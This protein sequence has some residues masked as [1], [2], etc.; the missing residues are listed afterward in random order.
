MSK[1]LSIRLCSSFEQ[2]LSKVACKMFQWSRPRVI[3][4]IPQYIDWKFLYLCEKNFLWWC[5]KETSWQSLCLK[6]LRHCNL[7]VNVWRNYWTKKLTI[8][9]YSLRLKIK[10]LYINF[11]MFLYTCLSQTRI[12][13]V[14]RKKYDRVTSVPWQRNSA[15]LTANCTLLQF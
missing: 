3:S 10:L 6:A 5:N 9:S 13:E 11:S 4:F 12:T 15:I 1:I 2:I 7:S 8:F 14:N